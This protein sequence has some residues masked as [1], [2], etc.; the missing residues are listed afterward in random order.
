MVVRNRIGQAALV[1][2]GICLGA[3][4]VA[5]LMSF[6]QIGGEGRGQGPEIG[7]YR[8]ASSNNSL[9]LNDTATGECWMRS[10]NGWQYMAAPPARR[11]APKP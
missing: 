6:A 1:I 2:A 8:M 11:T 5:P 4:I 3:T 9:Y 10:G 7:R